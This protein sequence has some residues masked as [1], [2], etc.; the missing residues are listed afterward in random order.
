MTNFDGLGM[1]VPL[2]VVSPYAKKRYVSHV[3]YEHGSVLK[4]I[5]DTFG[6][7]RLAAADT[8]ANSPSQD[9]FDWKQPP[10]KFVK[11]PSLYNAQFFM[12]RPIDRRL[13]RRRLRRGPSGDVAQLVERQLC[14]LDARGSSPLISTFERTRPSR[15]PLFVDTKAAVIN[16]PLPPLGH[17]LYRPRRGKRMSTG[18]GLGPAGCILFV[19]SLFILAMIVWTGMIR[20][21]CGAPCMH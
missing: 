15:R 12:N 8:R 2:L 17:P 5:E 6:F 16:G 4:F 3:Q 13:P 14:K 19:G 9:C 1:R 21:H 10:R 18:L 20:V 11:I 7:P